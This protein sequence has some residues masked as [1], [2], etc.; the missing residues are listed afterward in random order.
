MFTVFASFEM[1]FVSIR[2]SRS[3]DLV[4][5]LFFFDLRHRRMSFLAIEVSCKVLR[6]LLAARL[7]WL[8]F[9]S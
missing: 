4:V 1:R 6:V 9:A 8:L 5:V 2:R 7:E 3:L